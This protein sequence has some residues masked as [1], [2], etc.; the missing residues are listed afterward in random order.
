MSHVQTDPMWITLFE[1]ATGEPEG[2]AQIV[3]HPDAFHVTLEWPDGTASV[4]KWQSIGSGGA[5]VTVG[6]R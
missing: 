5:W 3:F 1:K 4:L 6:E 2:N